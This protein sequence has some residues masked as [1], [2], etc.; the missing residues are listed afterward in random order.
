MAEWVLYTAAFI[1]VS[2]LLAPQL[3]AFPY[4]AESE[5]GTVWSERP[6]DDAALAQVSARTRNL[7]A[8]SPIAE[9]N[10]TR[11]IF[12]TDGGWRWTWLANSSRG[13]FGLTRMASNAVVIGDTDLVN[14]TVT[15]HAGNT[16]SLSSVLA[17]EFTHGILR[18]RYGR[19]AMATEED[20][21]VEGYAE[22][23]AQETSLSAEDVER[24]EA[25]GEDHPALV[26]YYGRERVEAELAAN[27]G[28]VDDLFDQTD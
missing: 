8:E 10:E 20:W 17:H 18:R 1:F 6:I 11:P 19:I 5:I 26:Y 3:L 12:L 7:L 9:S 4:K 14:D 25:R 2:P 21:K 24:L 16:R 27:G 28:S 13:G 23:V 15:S 22:H